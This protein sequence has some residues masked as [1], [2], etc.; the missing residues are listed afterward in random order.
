MKIC[1]I[2]STV[3]VTP[4]KNYGGLEQIA[5]LQ[6]KG[7]G[8][9]GHQV[10]LVSPH[11][12]TVTKNVELH[13]TTL[14]EGEQQAYSG[15]WQKLTNFDV[16]IDSSWQKWSYILKMEGKLKAPILGVLHA[17]VHTMYNAFP[18]VPKPCI[19]C[20]SKDQAVACKEHL[21]ID[22]R[23]AYNGIDIDDYKPLNKLRNNRYLFLA[24]MSSIK[25]PDIACNLARKCKIGLDLVGDDT[26]TG[27]PD[28]MRNIFNSCSTFPGLRYIGPQSR[29]QCVKWFN[30]NKALIHP[31]ERFREPFGLAPVEAMACGMPVIAWNNGAMRETIK[32]GETGF[33]V[34]SLD[35][36]EKLILSDA[37]SSIKP[38]RCREWVSQ[39]S[40]E[41]MV[42]RYEELCKEALSTGGW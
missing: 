42:K 3:F 4:L 40:V 14:F 31:N 11:G 29:D 32:H 36:M 33:V 1:V 8:E 16:I 34:N 38:G 21:K 41:N 12:S 35:E 19:V 18:P 22:S 2:S 24:R 27:E 9:L 23:V 13:G 6:A 5:W 15:Y 26:I 39:F 37:V 28:L 17:P 10:T 25:G 30:T 20:I 7:L